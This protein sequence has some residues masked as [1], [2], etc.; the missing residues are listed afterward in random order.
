M[1]AA[2]E[3]EGADAAWVAAG[4]NGLLSAAGMYKAPFW[5]QAASI[6]SSPMASVT[7]ASSG[8]AALAG[9]DATKVCR[10]VGAPVAALRHKLPSSGS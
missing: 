10:P 8:L 1:G 5:P 6:T 9:Q 2:G 3:A 7:T 4:R